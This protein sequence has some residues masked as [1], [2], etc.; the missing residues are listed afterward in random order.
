VLSSFVTAEE[1]R[2]NLQHRMYFHTA[3]RTGKALPGIRLLN[4]HG[5]SGS[6]VNGF[7]NHINH[8]FRINYVTKNAAARNKEIPVSRINHPIISNWISLLQKE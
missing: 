5:L 3:V 8:P 1:R 6:L 4:F 7:N 2:S